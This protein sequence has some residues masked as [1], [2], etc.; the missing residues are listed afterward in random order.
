[1]LIPGDLRII[2]APAAYLFNKKGFAAG[3]YHTYLEGL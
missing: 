2:C 3:V 1:M